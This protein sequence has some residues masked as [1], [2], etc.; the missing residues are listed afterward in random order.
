MYADTHEVKDESEIPLYQEMAREYLNL[1]IQVGEAVR[2][3]DGE[4][5]RTH[6]DAAN[7]TCDQ[8]HEKFRD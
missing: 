1:M 7:E 8:C 3:K 2:A 5:A 4:T 6:F